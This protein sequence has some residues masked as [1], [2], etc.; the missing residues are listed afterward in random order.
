MEGFSMRNLILTLGVVFGL[1][2]VPA[3]SFDGTSTVLAFSS[4]STD[5]SV[6][7]PQ[8]VPK[9]KIDIDINKG[10]GGGRAWYA[11]PVWIAIG[12]IALVVLVLLVVTVSKGGGGTTIVRG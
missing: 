5:A 8:E 7:S 6:E 2:F 4:S 10:G 3:A 1:F 12:G 11:N 9:A